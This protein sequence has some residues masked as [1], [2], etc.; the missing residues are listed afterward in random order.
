V[1]TANGLYVV[2]GT[3]YAIA[4]VHEYFAKDDG[5]LRQKLE[6]A[7]GRKTTR[8]RLGWGRLARA[9]KPDGQLGPVFWLVDDP[10]KPLGDH[11]ALPHAGDPR[12]AAI[13]KALN[14]RMAQPLHMPAWDFRGHTNWTTAADG[15]GLCEPSVYRRPDGVLVKLSRDLQHSRRIYAATSED[16]ASFAPA[17]R[18]SIPD[19]PSKS[20]SGTLP[21]G[22]IYLVGNQSIGRD[23]LVISLSRDGVVFDRAAAIRAG[24]PRVRIRGRAKGPGFQYPAVTI[25]GD[26]LW[27]IYSIGKEDVAVSRVPLAALPRP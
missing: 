20:V 17:I 4:E 11:P 8:G 2:D 18:T 15:H 5:E 26:A 7:T 6:A 24:A 9:V 1:L 22:R 19:A 14:Q 12:F 3:V 16:G 10:P 23:P 25:V 21:D 13:A 27:A